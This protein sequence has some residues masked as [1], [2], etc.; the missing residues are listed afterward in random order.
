MTSTRLILLFV[1]V[2]LAPPLTLSA[3]TTGSLTDDEKAAG[4]Q[5]LFDGKSL[6]GWR[7]YLRSPKASPLIRTGWKVEDG[8]LKK[9]KGVYGGDI[10]TE[11]TF[12]DFELTWDWRIEK[13]GN[14]GIKYLVTEKR[15]EAPGHEYQMLDDDSAKYIKLRPK[16][17]TA[18][19]CEVVAP[20]ADRPLKPPGEWN[21]SRILVSGNRVEHWLNNR[22]VLEYELGSD[23]LRKAMETSKFKNVPGFGEKIRGHIML[24]DHQEETWFRNIK[25]RNL[26]KK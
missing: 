26:T 21:T 5:L 10:I 19:F 8:L 4:W 16:D 24:T 13:D 1:L 6:S 17:K 3:E 18:S 11:K 9:L 25:L 22:K 2:T 7:A 15:P 12:E 23:A 20:V 14:N